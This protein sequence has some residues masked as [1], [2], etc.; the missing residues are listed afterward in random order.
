MKHL[1][2]LL[3][4]FSLAIAC[5]AAFAQNN[6]DAGSLIKEG[7]QLNNAGKYAEAI[8]KYNQALKIDPENVYADYELAFSLFALN[9]GKEAIPYLEKV[10]KANSS[11]N[12]GAYDLLGNIYDKDN[13]TEK[14]H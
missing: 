6:E 3:L 4:F 9:K 14:A 8:D 11:L 10:I 7:V 13:Q 1:Y 12:A 2:K 5:E